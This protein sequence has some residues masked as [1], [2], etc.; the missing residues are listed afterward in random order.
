MALFGV[1]NTVDIHQEENVS[2]EKIDTL[3]IATS[4][5]DVEVRTIT[6][7][8]IEILLEGKMS[9]NLAENYNFKIIQKENRL[10]VSFKT[11]QSTGFQLGV[12]ITNIK[13]KLSIPKKIYE[14]LQ[15]ETSSGSI[16]L[17]DI[18]AKM[19]TSISSSGSQTI[20]GMEVD[21]R[22]FVKSSSGSINANENKA[23]QARIRA[24][25]GKIMLRGLVSNDTK[26][27][28]SSGSIYYDNESVNGYLDCKASSGK[29]NI[30]LAESPASL[31]VE[32]RANS[33]RV[34]V[35]LSEL[36]FKENS[37]HRIV[38]SRGTGENRI[39]AR[40]SSGSITVNER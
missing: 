22:L 32:G 25:S 24:S 36:A 21:K 16:H 1:N 37:D 31:Y 5:A 30:Q 33:G 15:I 38:A 34:R 9:E 8:E 10:E 14:D 4:S 2:A 19:L 13:L 18:S 29:V 28:T 17:T 39:N 11:K 26:L 35:Q 40:T 6:G 3:Y 20:S 7:S 12:T 27:E 23:G